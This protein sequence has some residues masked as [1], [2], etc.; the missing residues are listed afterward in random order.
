MGRTISR[1]LP[2]GQKESYEYDNNSNLIS[3]I[4][5]NGRK[6][7]Y[8]YDK[9]NQLTSKKLADGKITKYS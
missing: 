9:K 4:D 7:T 6:S 1:T 2:L 3:V 8:T 5:F